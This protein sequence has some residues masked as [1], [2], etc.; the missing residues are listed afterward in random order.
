M[1]VLIQRRLY[2][3]NVLR[4]QK[5]SKRLAQWDLKQRKTLIKDG[6]LARSWR[7][8]NEKELWL[9]QR[10]WSL[11][12]CLRG[13]LR[14]SSSRHL[15]KESGHLSHCSL[16]FV[17]LAGVFRLDFFHLRWV[18]RLDSFHSHGVI[19]LDPFYFTTKVGN[20]SRR[21][22]GVRGWTSICGGGS[23]CSRLSATGWSRRGNGGAWSHGSRLSASGWSRRGN[24][25]A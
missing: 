11:K 22:I 12:W 8:Y 20:L 9:V 5:W 10:P 25:G 6:V 24:G 23:R 1:N 19:W 13:R 16:D 3:K 17:H 21:T 18:F 4:V 7:L 14:G 2:Q 15:R